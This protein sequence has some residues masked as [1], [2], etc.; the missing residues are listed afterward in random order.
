M[1]EITPEEIGKGVRLIVTIAGIVAAIVLAV[2]GFIKFFV[3]R[4]EYNKL[5][6]LVEELRS[7][8]DELRSNQGRLTP[9]AEAQMIKVL[10]K[11]E[12]H[13]SDKQRR[14]HG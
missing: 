7:A 11:I 10:Q 12:D 14:R 8:Q 4:Y 6:K 13:F 1:G 9:E 2:V 5:L 3:T